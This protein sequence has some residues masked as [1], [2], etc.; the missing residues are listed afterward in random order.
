VGALFR[1][2]VQ[3]EVLVYLVLTIGAVFTARSLW[4]AWS[5]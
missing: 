3:Y 4:K 5:E 2:L 1:F